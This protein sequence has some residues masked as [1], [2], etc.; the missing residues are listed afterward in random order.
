VYYTYEELDVALVEGGDGR[1]VDI[2]PPGIDARA[3]PTSDGRPEPTDV[4]VIAVHGIDAAADLVL[5]RVGRV[6]RV[7]ANDVAVRG[8]PLVAGRKTV[9][10]PAV[11]RA[12]TGG[13][14]M[15]VVDPQGRALSATVALSSVRHLNDVADLPDALDWA[16]GVRPRARRLPTSLGRHARTDALADLYA[17]ALGVVPT[18]RPPGRRRR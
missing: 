2:V 18:R 14:A 10:C 15:V 8:P 12:L 17:T 1:R 11:A 4:D 3:A 9:L 13:R 16:A 6:G 5:A 7:A